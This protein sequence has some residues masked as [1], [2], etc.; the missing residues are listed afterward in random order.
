[1]ETGDYRGTVV[2]KLPHL[3]STKNSRRCLPPDFLLSSAVVRSPRCIFSWRDAAQ[4][5]G[6]HD[7]N[8]P[9][10]GGFSSLRSL[11]IGIFPGRKKVSQGKPTEKWVIFIR[12]KKRCWL[13]AIRG[14]AWRQGHASRL[15]LDNA[16]PYTQL[17]QLIQSVAVRL[18][19]C[20]QTPH[21]GPCVRSSLRAWVRGESFFGSGVPFGFL[22]GMLSYFPPE[23]AKYSRS[24]Y[25]GECFQSISR[26]LSCR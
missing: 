12:V 22:A 7:K 14:G 26:C 6:R 19:P 4:R 1:M 2:D 10:F 15:R 5:C 11:K 23:C 20:R 3:L 18:D 8:D 9:L 16:S 24:G 25:L 21:K 13:S 17:A